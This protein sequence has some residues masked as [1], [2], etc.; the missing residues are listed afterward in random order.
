MELARLLNGIFVA[1]VAGA[2]D[3]GHAAGSELSH[4]A[5]GAQVL[6]EEGIGGGA[7]FRSQFFQKLLALT[8]AA[9]P[10]PG[11]GEPA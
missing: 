6:H 4:K 9:S 11:R 10:G 3:R 7:G 2:V 8:G 5:I 1:L